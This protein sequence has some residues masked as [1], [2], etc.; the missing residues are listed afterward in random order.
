MAKEFS[1][2]LTKQIKDV[3]IK[4]EEVDDFTG[5]FEIALETR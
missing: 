5:A 3:Q 1:E 2:E 4:L